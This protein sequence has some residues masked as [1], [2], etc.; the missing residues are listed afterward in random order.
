MYSDTK[1]LEGRLDGELTWHSDN[2]GA[3]VFTRH[4]GE[5]RYSGTI[6]R[7]AS[8]SWSAFVPG[9]PHRLPVVFDDP[10]DAAIALLAMARGN[11]RDW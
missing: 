10:D 8:G 2:H 6:A 1:A 11:G 3:A 4:G 7:T 5:C 9:N